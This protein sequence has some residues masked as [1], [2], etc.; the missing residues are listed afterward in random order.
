MVKDDFSPFKRHSGWFSQCACYPLRDAHPGQLEAYW[1][2]RQNNGWLDQ[3]LEWTCV[4]PKNIAGRVTSLVIDP[5]D[6]KHL[7]AGSAAGGVWSSPDGGMTWQPAWP[8]WASQ[9][10][11]ALAF[12][13]HDPKVLYCATGEANISPDCYPGSGIYVSR[14]SG[15]TWDVLAVADDNALPRRIGTLVSSP[16]TAG[17]LY[18]GGVNLDEDQPGGF[19]QSCDG[20]KTWMREDSFSANTYWCHSIALHPDG[21]IFAALEMR[22]WQTGIYRCDK[23]DPKTWKQLHDRLPSGDVTGRISLAI[24]PS[25]PDTIYALVSDPLGSEVLGVYRSRTRGDRWTE[26]GGTEFAAEDQGCYNNVVA[27]HPKNP[28]IVACGLNDIHIT[29]DSGASWTR[30]SHWDAD[31]GTAQYVHGD[32]HAVLF[33]GEK[34]IFAANDGGVVISEDLGAS[35]HDRGKGMVT[36]MF[37]DIDVA[38]TDGKILGGGTQDNGSLVTGVT[39][40]EGEFLRVLDGDGAWM[41][42]DPKDETHV[43]GSK[44]DIHI[45]R[46]S[47]SKHWV[48]DFWEEVSPKGLKETEHHQVAVAVLAIDP[49]NGRKLWAGSKRLWMTTDDGREWTP[50]SPVFDNTAITAIEIPAAGSGQVFV[51]TKRGGIFRSLDDGETWSG[52]LSGPEIPMRTVTRIETHPRKASRV[53]ATVGGTGIV[54]RAIP[55]KMAYDKPGP[56]TSGVENIAHVFLSEDGGLTWKAIDTPEMPKVAYHAAV[57]ETHE[58]YRLFVSNDC[59]VWMTADLATWT[60][61]SM[62]L[63][64]VMIN[65][66]VYHDRDRTLTAATYGR[67]IWRAAIPRLNDATNAEPKS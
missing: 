30:A 32:Q 14:D 2:D 45:F 23:G 54:S 36:T 11:G 33:T 56:L 55:R 22:G 7:I 67:G 64:N 62:T 28:D 49:D 57:F 10:I 12:D 9:S 66:L 17:L 24:A 27:V 25:Q 31:E 47:A 46:H 3:S 42:F 44:S 50:R 39:A 65:D 29:T 1:K 20:G 37:Y 13:A 52:N 41:V 6:D 51:G 63:P 5:A 48:T 35:W 26:I 53:V 38:P 16:L 15:S 60:D 8:K 61:L 58:P 21:T 18:L 59:G 43:F 19:Y 4:G 34:T 40:N